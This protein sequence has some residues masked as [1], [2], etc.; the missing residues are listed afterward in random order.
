MRESLKA[1]MGPVE[2]GDLRHHIARDAVVIVDGSLDLLDV[3]EAVGRDQ[4][5]LVAAWVE[6]GLLRKPSLE[7][8]ERWSRTSGAAW[9]IVV[10]QPFVL[11]REHAPI[12]AN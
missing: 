5:E 11:I 2:F 7:D 10:V 3:G 8:L 6:K 1:A 4:K 9:T 12:S